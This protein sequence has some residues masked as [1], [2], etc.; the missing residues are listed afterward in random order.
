MS[1]FSIKPLGS[2][3]SVTA[4]NTVANSTF[5]RIYAPN[6]TLITVTHASSGG[7]DPAITGNF[8]MPAGAVEYVKKMAADT[9]TANV[10]VN[11]CPVAFY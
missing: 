3:I 9:I 5:V 1:N 2:E 10:A 4:A 8:T 11:C 7:N 6:T